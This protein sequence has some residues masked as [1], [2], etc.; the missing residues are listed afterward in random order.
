ML[1][2]GKY[3][4][5]ESA[6]EWQFI[7]S[8]GPGGQNVNKVASAARLIFPLAKSCMIDPQFQTLLTEKLRDKLNAAGEL[9]IVSHA[10][11]SQL[12]NRRE[13]LDKLAELLEAA[14][15]VRKKRR[16]TKPTRAGIRRRLEAKARHSEI[17][18]ERSSSHTEENN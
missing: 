13:A 4:I 12:Q 15:T 7:Q 14:L 6:F 18:R 3:F 16:P 1:I 11:R 2:Q 10:S 8:P 5:P 9:V 17:K